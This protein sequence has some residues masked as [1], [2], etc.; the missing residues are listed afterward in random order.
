MYIVLYLIEYCVLVLL[1]ALVTLGAILFT[2]LLIC[3][4]LT[5]VKRRRPENTGIASGMSFLPHRAVVTG[6]RAGTLDRRAMI[7]DTSSEGSDTLP[8]VPKVITNFVNMLHK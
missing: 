3:I 2:L 5:C 4:V 7:Q 1:I 8:Y 6:R